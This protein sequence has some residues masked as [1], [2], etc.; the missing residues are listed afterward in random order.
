[1]HFT[2]TFGFGYSLAC[3]GVTSH[4]C[5]VV[6]VFHLEQLS[7]FITCDAL[8]ASWVEVLSHSL[9]EFYSFQTSW[10]GIGK[11]IR[12]NGWREERRG[13]V[14]HLEAAEATGHQRGARQAAAATANAET[15]AA[16]NADSA[17]E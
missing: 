16:A 11:S 9:S 14:P 5:S 13:V 12:G 2:F 3:D 10:S 8:H 17:T 1:M 6:L 4:I 7:G 15:G